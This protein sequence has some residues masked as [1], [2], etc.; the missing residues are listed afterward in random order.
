MAVRRR[1]VSAMPP[2][3]LF[4][5]NPLDWPGAYPDSFE[6]WCAARRDWVRAHP[7]SPLGNMLDLLRG[8]RKARQELLG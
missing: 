4:A 1:P 7:D 3:E 6:L 2:A 5:Y 8:E